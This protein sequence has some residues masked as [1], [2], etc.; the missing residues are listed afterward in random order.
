LALDRYIFPAIF[1]PGEER[2]YVVTFPDL[3]GIVTQGSDIPDAL[4]MARDAL[5]LHLYGMEEDRE[6]IPEPTPPHL[7]HTSPPAFVTMIDVNS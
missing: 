5:E 1:E 2:Y 3:P 6:I 4:A 7:V